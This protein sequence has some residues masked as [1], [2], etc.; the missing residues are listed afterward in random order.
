M[1]RAIGVV[2]SWCTY[3]IVGNARKM[4]PGDLMNMPIEKPVMGKSVHPI[5]KDLE[6]KIFRTR[7]GTIRR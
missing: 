7:R 6:G 4:D 1:A 5:E 2:H 3:G